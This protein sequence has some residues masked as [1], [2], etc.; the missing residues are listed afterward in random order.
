MYMPQV[1]SKNN[2]QQE[3]NENKNIIIELQTN[4]IAC[5]ELLAW[6]L[7]HS[8]FKKIRKSQKIVTVN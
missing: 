7:P 4:T 6:Y 2:K 8:L 1:K 5:L 3:Y